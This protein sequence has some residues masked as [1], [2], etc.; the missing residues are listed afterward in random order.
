[1]LDFKCWASLKWWSHVFQILPS[2]D[3]P[4]N[5]LIQSGLFV[6][7]A[8]KDLPQ[9][10]WLRSIR[11]PTVTGEALI[12]PFS[13]LHGQILDLSMRNFRS[14][15]ET[16]RNAIEP[17]L[18]GIVRSASEASVEYNDLKMVLAEKHE[19]RGQDTIVSTIRQICFAIGESFYDVQEGKNSRRR[20]VKCE[21]RFVQYEAEFDMNLWRAFS[22]GINDASKT[23][24]HDFVKSRTI[25]VPI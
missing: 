22:A 16:S 20:Y 21:V 25:C 24:C 11:E 10:P 19:Y 23:A 14:L 18:Q 6:Q 12:C 17:V 3:D 7:I 13:E 4:Y 9:I 2:S 15:D 5:K 1:M 8:M